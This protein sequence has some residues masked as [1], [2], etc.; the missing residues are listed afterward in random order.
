MLVER[1]NISFY[2]LLQNQ[3]ILNLGLGQTAIYFC[4][5]L[6]LAMMIVLGFG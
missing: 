6:S 3:V 4:I 1:M 2:K 5:M